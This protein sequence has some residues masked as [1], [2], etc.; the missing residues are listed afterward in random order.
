M[1][2]PNLVK[3]DAKNPRWPPRNL[4][5]LTFKH[6]TAVISRAS[7]RSP[8]LFL[9][10]PLGLYTEIIKFPPSSLQCWTTPAGVFGSLPGPQDS[11]PGAR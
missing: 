8:C 10:S 7:S 3:I 4:V 2:V 6:L 9:L 5:F 1:C 11:S